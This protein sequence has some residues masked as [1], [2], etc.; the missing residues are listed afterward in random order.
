[1]KES[2]YKKAIEDRYPV[3]I[4]V[5][6][7]F[8]QHVC[9]SV[10]FCDTSE[11]GRINSIMDEDTILKELI[12]RFGERIIKPKSRYFYDF[13]FVQDENTRLPFNIKCSNG[14]TDNAMNKKA[15][16]YSLTDLSNE[17]IHSN[18]TYNVMRDKIDNNLKCKRDTSKEYYYIYI[19]KKDK[20]IIIKSLLD[21]QNK[22]SNPSNIFQ[23]DWKAE[24]K[25]AHEFNCPTN[26]E[27]ARDHIYDIIYNSL[28]KY[29]NSC[30]KFLS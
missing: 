28:K 17:N 12:E 20:T 22:K 16:V 4:M 24:K 25:V 7:E 11:D 10:K 27:T 8:L 3:C 19:G 14:G 18:M 6:Y 30:S 5:L 13:M 9:T 29:F 21:I 26:I 1:M 2:V 23:I 15:I